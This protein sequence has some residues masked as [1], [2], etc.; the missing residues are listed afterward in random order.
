[1]PFTASTIEKQKQ[2]MFSLINGLNDTVVLWFHCY[3]IIVCCHHLL[4][5]WVLF[6]DLDS[7]QIA[8]AE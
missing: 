2:E 1:M 5:L 4:Q 3:K 8:D 7:K 6:Y